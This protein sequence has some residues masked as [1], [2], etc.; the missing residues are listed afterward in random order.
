MSTSPSL[1]KGSFFPYV[2]HEEEMGFDKLSQ[3]GVE[4]AYGLSCR[5]D[6]DRESAD[7]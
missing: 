5:G 2:S 7:G 1:S 3:V 4:Y 6:F